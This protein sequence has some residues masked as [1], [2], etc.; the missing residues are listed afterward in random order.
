MNNKENI[1]SIIIKIALIIGVIIGVCASLV[2]EGFFNPSHFLYYTVQS[3]IEMEIISLVCLFFLFK[4]NGKIPQTVYLLKFIFTVAITLTGMVFNF[5]LYPQG[6]AHGYNINPLS[7]A[8][9]FT[10]I[11]VPV[12]SLVDFFAFDYK[13]KIT[14]K[15][16][17]L[18]LITPLLYFVFVLFCTF[19]GIKFNGGNFVPYFFLDY[20]INGWFTFQPGV[21]GVFYWII[22]QLILVLLISLVLIFFLKIRKKYS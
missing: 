15:T 19:T 5:I 6:V 1:T 7:T 11:F 9:F 4:R 13:M 2:Q 22:V 3:N 8:N 17:L 14:N 10:H 18:G 20:K 21:I 12:I 16:F